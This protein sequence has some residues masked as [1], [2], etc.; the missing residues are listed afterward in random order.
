MMR[1]G[2]WYLKGWDLP[3]PVNGGSSDIHRTFH[4]GV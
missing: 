1:T 3:V 4:L 2:Y